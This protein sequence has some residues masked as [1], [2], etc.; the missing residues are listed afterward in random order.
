MDN[1]NI[2]D[3]EAAK[4]IKAKE[5]AS[6]LKFDQKPPQAPDDLT[7]EEVNTSLG[8]SESW[9]NQNSRQEEQAGV[10][11]GWKPFPAENLPS[12]GMFYPDGTTFAIRAA[13]VA[14]IRHFSTI[15]DNDP[16]DLDDHV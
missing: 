8:K 9:K 12:R 7:D 10:E 13:S 2:S 6:G 1:K 3:D 14:E 11:I 16:L 4:L 5:E 15:D